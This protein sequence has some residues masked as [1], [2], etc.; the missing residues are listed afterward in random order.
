VNTRDR[1]LAR[2]CGET[3]EQGPT[4]HCPFV[5][6]IASIAVTS[7][8]R[9][10]EPRHSSHSVETPKKKELGTHQPP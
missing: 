7:P 6:F 9:L 3:Q 8:M 10:Y 4:K 5:K 2:R 1:K